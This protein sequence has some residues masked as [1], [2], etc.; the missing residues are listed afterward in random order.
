MS[1]IEQL[2]QKQRENW[3][4]FLEDL[5]GM[6]LPEH[7]GLQKIHIRRWEICQERQKNCMENVFINIRYKMRFMIKRYLGFQVEH[8]GPKNVADET[9]SSVY[10]NETHMLRVLDI[11]LNKSYHKLGFQNGKG[12]TYE[13]TSYNKFHSDSTE[14]L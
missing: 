5:Y 9:D 14:I 8:N 12:R 6:V 11:I 10:D 4:D 1:V 2:H 3:N 13:G 7:L